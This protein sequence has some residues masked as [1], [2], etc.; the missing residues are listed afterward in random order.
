MI[1]ADDELVGSRVDEFLLKRIP[2]GWMDRL[3]PQREG[4]GGQ[5]DF[6]EEMLI[7]PS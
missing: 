3:F 2:E 4:G 6:S 7:P 1:P 5:E